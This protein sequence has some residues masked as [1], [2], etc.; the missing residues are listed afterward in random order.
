MLSWRPTPSAGALHPVHVLLQ[1]GPGCA[2]QRYCAGRDALVSI[3]GLHADEP[4]HAL[5]SYVNPSSSAILLFAADVGATFSKYR[6]GGSLVWRDAGV[7]QGYLTFLA[8]A[9]GL[10][11]VLLGATGEPWVRRF[12]RSGMVVGVGSALVGRAREGTAAGNA[13]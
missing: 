5:A 1:A 13:A 2:W 6:D 4:R 3:S 10:D 12:V 8:A 7:L 9:L 11:V